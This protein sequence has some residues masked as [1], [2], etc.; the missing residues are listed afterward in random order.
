[1]NLHLWILKR[2][3]SLCHIGSKDVSKIEVKRHTSR[4][5]KIDK[6]IPGLLFVVGKTGGGNIGLQSE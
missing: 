3:F 1:M 2:L 6:C 4:I 5:S